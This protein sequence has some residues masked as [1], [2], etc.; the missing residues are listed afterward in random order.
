MPGIKLVVQQ[1]VNEDFRLGAIHGAACFPILRRARSSDLA[2]ASCDSSVSVDMPK[3][4][5]GKILNRMNRL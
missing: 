4:L 3:C 1:R 2:P 5:S